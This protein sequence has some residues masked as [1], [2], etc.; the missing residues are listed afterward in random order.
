MV[1]NKNK[2]LKALDKA[3]MIFTIIAA[4]DG[5]PPPNNE[6]NRPTIKKNGAPGGCPTSNL[7]AQAIYSPQSQ[8]LAVGSMVEQKVNAAIANTAHPIM[9]FNL[10]NSLVIIKYEICA[11]ILFYFIKFNC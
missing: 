6:K 10:L 11:N 8:K 3:L 2:I 1:Q 5:S 9:L 4:F 7:Y